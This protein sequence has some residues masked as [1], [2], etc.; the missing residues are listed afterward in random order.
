MIKLDGQ[1]IFKIRATAPTRI[2]LAGGTIDLWPIH[3]VLRQK[4]TVNC[5]VS[6]NA[7]VE[8]SP[9]QDGQYHLISLDQN[10]SFSG[11]RQECLKSPK[12]PLLS[13]LIE[14]C[15]DG[16]LP[17]ITI[18]TAAKSPAG[19]GLGGSSCLA[20]TI[21]AALEA[22][23]RAVGDTNDGSHLCE[24][25]LVQMAAD[26]E[27]QLIHAPTGIQDYWGAIR[28]GLNILEYPRG[29]VQVETFNN[30]EKVGAPRKILDRI[31]REM[32][33]CYSG[34]SRQSAINNWEIFKR[35]FDGDTRLIRRLEQIGAAANA[36]AS[37]VREG[38]YDALIEASQVEWNLRCELWPAIHSPETAKLA[39]VART[40]GAKLT[41]VCGAGGGGVIAIF[42]PITSLAEIQ[43]SLVA[44][45]GQILPAGLVF[46]GLTTLQIPS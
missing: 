15:W 46:D 16:N 7:E 20:V 21:I 30:P 13:L 6:L 28:G 36:C 43:K 23:K 19:A 5:A 8:V 4:A 2:D 31:S 11:S 29:R 3:Q 32:I 14:A 34:K 39:E 38:D 24:S 40:A 35:V 18:K 41:R 26:V 17:P 10:Q 22:A 1:P 37:A 27:A 9:S 42:A 45:G 25:N 12:L 44:S 33:L